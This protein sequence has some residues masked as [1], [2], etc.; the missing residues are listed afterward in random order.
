M[1]I[2]VFNGRGISAVV[3]LRDT[4]EHVASSPNEDSLQISIVVVVF[5]SLTDTISNSRY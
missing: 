1:V 2:D 5:I 3:P 4:A